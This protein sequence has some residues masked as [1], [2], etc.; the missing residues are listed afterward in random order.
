MSHSQN[1][2]TEQRWNVAKLTQSTRHRL[3][4]SK[5][6]RLVV[7]ALGGRT[8]TMFLETLAETVAARERDDTPDETEIQHVAVS[9]HH[10]HLPM[11][12]DAEVLTY[13]PETHAIEPFD[14]LL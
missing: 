1:D 8:E 2:T 14:V 13:D 11:M 3:L 10:T 6:R 5:R 12:D 9:L 7:D 4:K